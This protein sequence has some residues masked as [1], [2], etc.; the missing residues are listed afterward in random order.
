MPNRDLIYQEFGRALATQ[1]RQKGFSQAQFG[2]KVGLSR[3]SITNIERGRQPIQLHQLYFF[4]SVLSVDVSRLLPKAPSESGC[5]RASNSNE[6]QD[7]Y[8]AKLEKVA[9]HSSKI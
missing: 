1:R 3:T 2:A 5:E 4:S 7:H 8:L 6:R 9:I